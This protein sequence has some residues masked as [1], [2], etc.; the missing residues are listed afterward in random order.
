[1]I[2]QESD[3]NAF[4]F[5]NWLFQLWFLYKSNLLNSTAEKKELSENDNIFLIIDQKKVWKVQLWIGLCAIFSWRVTWN[6]A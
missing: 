1:M 6:D 2:K 3:I 5:E 4:I